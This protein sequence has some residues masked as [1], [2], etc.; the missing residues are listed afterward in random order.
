M[1]G[2]TNLPLFFPSSC[3][4]CHEDDSTP[5]GVSFWQGDFRVHIYRLSE[6][7]IYVVTSLLYTSL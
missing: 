7:I 2:W 6:V 4:D 3:L 5:S 1:R